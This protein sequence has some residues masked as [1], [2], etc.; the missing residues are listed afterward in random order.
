[1]HAAN[2]R[3]M[4]KT[5]YQSSFWVMRKDGDG[6]LAGLPLTPQVSTADE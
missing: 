3:S 2:V 5:V 1:M 4:Y 6:M